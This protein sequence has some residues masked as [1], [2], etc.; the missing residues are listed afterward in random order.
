M[1]EG[2]TCD[3]KPRRRRSQSGPRRAAGSCDEQGSSLK[4]QHYELGGRGVSG[5]PVMRP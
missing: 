4:R 3:A 1:V 2:W 5:S